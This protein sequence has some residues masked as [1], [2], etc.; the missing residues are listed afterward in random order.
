MGAGVGAGEGVGSGSGSRS[1]ASPG[2][3]LVAGSGITGVTRSPVR[4][5]RF[6]ETIRQTA[7]PFWKRTTSSSPTY[8]AGSPTRNRSP[9]LSPGASRR[10]T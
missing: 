4:I 6:T 2:S 9:G 1:A 7:T 8:A 5:G 10:S 3:E